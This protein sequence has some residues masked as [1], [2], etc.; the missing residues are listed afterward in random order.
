MGTKYRIWHGP[1]GIDRGEVALIAEVEDQDG[2]K[3]QVTLT[4]PRTVPPA[5][6]A[7]T[8]RYDTAR[9]IAGS[10]GSCLALV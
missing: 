2:F 3:W 10:P 7:H 5:L 8:A 9:W 1:F 6:L 4:R